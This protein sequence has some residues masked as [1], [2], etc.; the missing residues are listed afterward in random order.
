MD[1]SFRTL[2]RRLAAWHPQVERYDLPQGCG[3]KSRIPG[4]DRDLLGMVKWPL[5]SKV[6]KVVG[7]LQRSGI[8]RSRLKSPGWWFWNSWICLSWLFVYSTKRFQSKNHLRV[9]GFSFFLHIL[10][11]KTYISFGWLGLSLASQ[12]ISYRSSR[13]CFGLPRLLGKR[14]PVAKPATV[15]STWTLKRSGHPQFWDTKRTENLWK[16]RCLY[17]TCFYKSNMVWNIVVWSAP[18]FFGRCDKCFEKHGICEMRGYFSTS[19]TAGEM[20]SPDE[21]ENHQTLHWW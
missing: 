6:W 1:D 18:G 13:N 20:K 5:K 21:V 3:G 19:F 15:S 2:Q 7:D 12:C 17:C 16:P 4:C 8:I 11:R 14:L 10:K 9:S